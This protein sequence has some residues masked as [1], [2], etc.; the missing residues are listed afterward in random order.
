[1]VRG[2]GGRCVAVIGEVAGDA[3]VGAAGPAFFFIRGERVVG[4]VR[5]GF[6]VVVVVA[7]TTDKEDEEDAD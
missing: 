3:V 7:V 2:A 6:I 1:M 4:L 5:R